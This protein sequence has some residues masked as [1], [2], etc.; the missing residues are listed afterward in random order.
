MPERK[1]FQSPY[2][3]LVR[4]IRA[5]ADRYERNAAHLEKQAGDLMT[6][7]AGPDGPERRAAVVMLSQ[8]ATD[9]GYL[10]AAAEELRALLPK[11]PTRQ[12]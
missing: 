3:R 10:Q 8:N 11:R 2:W 7:A 4:D 1:P 6:T 12:R 9:I 5:L